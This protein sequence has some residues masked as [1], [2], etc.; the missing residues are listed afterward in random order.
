[1]DETKIIVEIQDGI[2]KGITSNKD[3]KV[4]VVDRDT[5][6]IE[7]SEIDQNKSISNFLRDRELSNVKYEYIVSNEDFSKNIII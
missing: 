7:C 5:Q 1:M 4:L 3:V 2:I 6:E